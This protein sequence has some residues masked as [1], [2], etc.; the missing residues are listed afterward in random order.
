M[1]LMAYFETHLGTGVLAT[2]NKRGG[3]NMAV[4][5]RPH[6]KGKNRVSFIMKDRLSHRNLKSNPKA[7]YLF[8]DNK[9]PTGGV[10]LY[11]TMTG[12][13]TDQNIVLAERRRTKP[14]ENGEALFLVHFKVTKARALIGDTEYPL[15]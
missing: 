8:T 2:S 4:Y 12:E 10:R 5:S 7:A 15:A 14:V 13:D 3:V 1:N 6:V 11:L 9:K